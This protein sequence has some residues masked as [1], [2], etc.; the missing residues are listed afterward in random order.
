MLA[1]GAAPRAAAASQAA[2]PSGPRVRRSPRS[3]PE[4]LPHSSKYVSST[5][6]HRAGLGHQ[7]DV[8]AENRRV[9]A[10]RDAAVAIVQA[11]ATESVLLM[12]RAERAEDPW[13]GHW[14]FPGGRREPEDSDLLHTALR[15]LEEECG[16]HLRREQLEEALPAAEARRRVGPYLQVAPFVFRVD[17]EQPVTLDSREAAEAQWVPLCVLRDPA[18]HALRP[19]PGLPP[20]VRFP[21]VDLNCVP[22]WGFTYRLITDWLGLD[23]PEGCVVEASFQAAQALLDGLLAN[24]CALEHGWE[25]R[26]GA[27]VA[28]VR[29]TIPV[30][31]VW[32]QSPAAPNIPR[33]NMLEVRP[34]YI[35]LVG[36][37]FEEY[38]IEAD[39]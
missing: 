6:G 28:A 38:I 20:E 33:V 10:E 11:C 25:D 7:P 9:T 18:H 14:S 29:G 17:H 39:K 12:R 24:G 1:C 2:R 34:D 31:L 26:D 19:V 27:K 3:Q 4:G 16:I 15:E 37:A 36:L 35:R 30:D 22:L 21:A 5:Q 13:S 32:A 23:P 8:L